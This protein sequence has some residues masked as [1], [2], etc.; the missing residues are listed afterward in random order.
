MDLSSVWIVED[1]PTFRQSLRDVLIQQ[2]DI[3]CSHVFS[4]CEDALTVLQKGDPPDIILIDIGL[5]GMSGIDGIAKMKD[6]SPGTEFIV[7]TIHEEDQKVFEAIRV[8]ASGY[9]LKIST[10]DEIV[11]A[12]RE[13]RSGG[14]ALSAGIARKILGI[15]TSTRAPRV[16]YN[17]TDRENEILHLLSEGLTKKRLADRLFLSPHT[18]DSHIRNIYSKLHVHS[19]SN[20][21][22]KAL[23]EKLI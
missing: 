9:L 1:E 15:L 12:I 4:C 20:A 13:V 21:V 17:L 3:E 5:P 8:G 18:V 19:R 7:L 2:N 23:R 11:K 10:S 22:A 14:A 16:D 6:L